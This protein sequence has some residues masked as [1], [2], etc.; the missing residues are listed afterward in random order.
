VSPD[1]LDPTELSKLDPRLSAW[2]SI[3]TA[4]SRERI[5]RWMHA[6][7]PPAP[8]P[9]THLFFTGAD[10]VRALVVEVITA[11]PAPAAIAALEQRWFEVGR[12]TRG[13]A[14]APGPRPPGGDILLAGDWC[15]DFVR[16][17]ACHEVGHVLHRPD[18]DP[19]VPRSGPPR[20]R[21]ETEAIGRALYA[22]VPD[23]DEIIARLLREKEDLAD[24]CAALWGYPRPPTDGT[25]FK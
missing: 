3:A 15:D 11:M 9:A 23:G 2:A 22:D 8:D 25:A 24:A 21:G 6:G 18:P 14:V 12:R 16:F 1:D 20:P 7:A 17:V 10:S 4:A 5:A 19:S 13:T